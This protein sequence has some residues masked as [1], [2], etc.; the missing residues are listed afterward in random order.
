MD[1]WFH[2][3]LQN[4]CDYLSMLG[5]MLNYVSKRGRGQR[6]YTTFWTG[7]I[8]ARGIRMLKILMSSK[9][10]NAR[11]LLVVKGTHCW[12]VDSPHRS[13]WRGP[14]MFSL[15]CAWTK[16]WANNRDAGDLRRRRVEIVWGTVIV[17]VHPKTIIKW[18]HLLRPFEQYF[19]FNTFLPWFYRC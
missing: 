5:L 19:K 10:N 12:T 6:Y 8:G 3:T 4:G 18:M 1:K 16:G 17:P 9:G 13:Q 14:L 11:Y 15:I 2:P 7:V